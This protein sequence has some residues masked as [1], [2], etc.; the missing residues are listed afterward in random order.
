M[1]AAI[2]SPEPSIAERV[3]HIFMDCLFRDSE[4]SPDRRTAPPDAILIQGIVNDFGLH[5]G[6]LVSHK[7]EIRALIDLMP[8]EFHRPN[9]GGGMTFLNLC[10]TRKGEQWGEHKNCEQLLVLA[11]AAQMG[12]Y[13]APREIW[14]ALPGHMPY[15]YFESGGP[16]DFKRS[17]LDGPV[18]E[19]RC[20]E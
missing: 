13:C 3:E 10:M 20:N 2:T 12:G 9:G 5:R 8:L 14:K 19:G 17:K 15:V 7:E 18:V 11:I 1:S 6:R 16:G 4:L